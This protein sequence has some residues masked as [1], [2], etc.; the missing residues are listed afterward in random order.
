MENFGPQIGHGWRQE[1]RKRL[2]GSRETRSP[3]HGQIGGQPLMAST[4][5]E[6]TVHTRA[7]PNSPTSTFNSARRFW[8]KV[9]DTTDTGTS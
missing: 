6:C 7:N 4:D 5:V 9:E 2:K 1:T 8:N 3:D